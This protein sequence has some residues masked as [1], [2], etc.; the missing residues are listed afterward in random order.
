MA[1]NYY[2]PCQELDRCNDLIE[3]YFLKEDYVPCFEGHLELAQ[4]GYPLAECQ[5][6]YFY[7]DGLGVEKDMEQALLWTRRGAEH[8]DRDAQFNLAWFYE[9]GL[10]IEKDIGKALY[11]YQEAAKQAH[12]GAEEKIKALLSA[13]S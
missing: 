3:K 6:G 13:T 11:W 12:D 8:G 1:S 9:E 4:Q 7:F 10:G 2:K 5:V